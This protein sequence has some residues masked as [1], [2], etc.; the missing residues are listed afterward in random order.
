M[1]QRYSESLLSGTVC[2]YVCKYVCIYADV[3]GHMPSPAVSKKPDL[4]NETRQVACFSIIFAP[5]AVNQPHRNLE[6][7]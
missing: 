4:T 3:S 2:T 6:F 1:N 5:T 7:N